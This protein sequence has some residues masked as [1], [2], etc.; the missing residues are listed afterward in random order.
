MVHMN[1]SPTSTSTSKNKT[2]YWNKSKDQF[3]FLCIYLTLAERACFNH[4]TA[5]H[6]YHLSQVKVFQPKLDR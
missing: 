6:L 1:L 5:S 4:N 2:R 3:T